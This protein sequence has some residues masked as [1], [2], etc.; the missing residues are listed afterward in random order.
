MIV[1]DN[2]PFRWLLTTNLQHIHG[3]DRLTPALIRRSPQQIA[4][5][6]VSVDRQANRACENAA[7]VRISLL[8][9][10]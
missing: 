7:S 6:L 3:L 5:T 9:F 4:A 2:N 1:L 10:I 8:E